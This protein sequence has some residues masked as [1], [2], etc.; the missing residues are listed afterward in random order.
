MRKT[1]K[2]LTEHKK[3]R[4]KESWNSNGSLEDFN[5]EDLVKKAFENKYATNSIREF[6]DKLLYI[7]VDPG[8]VFGQRSG[9]DKIWVDVV[10]IDKS[11]NN[12]QR[13]YMDSAMD[14]E[15]AAD[16]LNSW[17]EEYMTG[18]P[19]EEPAEEDIPEEDTADIQDIMDNPVDDN[20][21]EG[22]L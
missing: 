15:S 18:G 14:E 19:V 11:S 4:L 22:E 5:P 16:L 7:N 6:K 17:K 8:F 20:P 13:I 9:S 10:E 3:I 2:Q 1:Y 21:N 12:Q